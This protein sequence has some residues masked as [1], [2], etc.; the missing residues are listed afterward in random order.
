MSPPPTT[1]AGS[2]PGRTPRTGGRRSRPLGL[3]GGGEDDNGRKK[4]FS[5]CLVVHAVPDSKGSNFA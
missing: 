3:T 5:S 2:S 1:P 4:G